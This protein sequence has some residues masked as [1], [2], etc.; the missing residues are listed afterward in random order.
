MGDGHRASLGNL[1][2]EGRDNAAIA[3]EDVAEAHGG[4][5]G[6]L[7]S[8]Q[9]VDH[10][11]CNPFGRAHNARGVDGL[12]SRHKDKPLNIKFQGAL[13]RDPRT[14]NIVLNRL[15]RILLHQGHMLVSGGMKYDVWSKGVEDLVD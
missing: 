10:Q 14:S 7:C 11:L 15:A 2:K 12:V 6:A 3:S 9:V 5:A 13:G 4:K 8:V 1:R